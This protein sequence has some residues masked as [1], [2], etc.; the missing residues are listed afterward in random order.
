MSTNP[1]T[2]T[3]LRIYKALLVIAIVVAL[4]VF[5]YKNATNENATYP[6]K[7]GLDLAGGSHLVYEADVTS[8]DKAEVPE[9]M[10]VLREV[11]E[12][13][14]NAF[15]VSEP[16]VQVERSSFVAE[17]QSERLVVELPGVTDISAAVKEIGETPL[18]EFKLLDPNKVA[19]QEALDSLQ[20]L[21]ENASGSRALVGNVK[22]NGEEVEEE[23]PFVPT[24]L[25]GRY[26]EKATLEF[27]GG[28]SSQ[29]ANEPLVSVR[30]NEEGGKLFADITRNNVGQQL[31]IFLDGELLSA[32]VINEAITGGTAVISGDFTAD[33]ARNLAENLSFGALPMPIKLASTQ[34]IDASLGGGVMQQ[35]MKA[36]L[37]GFVLIS[38]FLII[39]YRGPGVVATFALLAY[40]LITLAIFLL[41]PVTLTAA[42]LAGMVL[43]LGMAVDANV[44]V[45]ER[46][47]EEYRSGKSSRDAIRDGFDRAWSAIRDGNVT[48]LISAVI[49]F[50]FG[51]SLIK[52]FALVLGIGTIISIVSAITITR[53]LLMV[54]P[55]VK[56]R[57]N[58]VWPWLF[59]TGIMK[60]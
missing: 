31:G 24:G 15:G 51:N 39:W 33:E 48:A 27:A 5:V 12:R 53:T 3:F 38:L 28:Q 8:L 30:F 44:L 41:V 59:G 22:V 56:S 14:V 11:I 7:F 4:G 47:K 19:E 57:D 26:L 1:K 43:S 6:F 46:L 54:L 32:P 35:I 36:G 29:L 49:L 20:S 55:D 2:D 34:T 37:L 10:E 45:F 9:L 21:T 50:W 16:V 60:K 40:V 42:G 25:T 58:G 52:G 23:D 13:R 17:K 18:L